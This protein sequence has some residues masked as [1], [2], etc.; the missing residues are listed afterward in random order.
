MVWQIN[1]IDIW[2]KDTNMGT[3]LSNSVPNVKED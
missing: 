1:V 2:V 3:N